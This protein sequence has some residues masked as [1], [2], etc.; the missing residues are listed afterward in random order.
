M[1]Q[2]GKQAADIWDHLIWIVRVFVVLNQQISILTESSS[3][4]VVKKVKESYLGKALTWANGQ[5]RGKWHQTWGI[6]WTYQ[7]ES[8]F[9]KRKKAKK[10]K[11]FVR[12]GHLTDWDVWKSFLSFEDYGA[13]SRT[14]LRCGLILL[15]TS[16][17]TLD[18]F[19]LLQGRLGATAEHVAK[20]N[21]TRLKMGS[22]SR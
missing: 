5:S 21:L 17:Q 11:L 10:S 12:K 6:C 15:V 9:E 13:L 3:F 22:L 8:S 1:K 4:V 14:E 16:D 7:H 2:K 18:H 19:D 20:V